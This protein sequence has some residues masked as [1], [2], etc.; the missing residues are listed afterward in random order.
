MLDKAMQTRTR[1]PGLS[2]GMALIVLGGLPTMAIV[3]LVPNLPQLFQQFS[4]VPNHE[5]W[6]PMI[7][8]MPSLCV[9][10]FSPLAG[11]IADFWG[12]RKLLIASLLLFSVVGVLPMLVNN[13]FTI[14]A[15][16]FFV[17]VAE[18]GI[19]TCGNALMGDYFSGAQRHLWLGR[20]ATLGTIL[21]TLFMLSGGAL[22]SQNWHAPFALYAIGLPVALWVLRDMWEPEKRIEAATSN[23]TQHS[24]FP[25]SAAALVSAATI[26]IAIIYFVQ[27]VQ[28]GR[29]FAD[30]GV[31]SPGRISV[32]TAMASIG[33]LL[34]GYFYRKVAAYGVGRVL[35]LAFAAFAIGYVGVSQAPNYW[36]GLP[37]AMISQFGNGLVFPALLNWALGNYDFEHRGRGMGLWGSCFFIGMFVSPPLVTAIGKPIGSFLQTVGVIGMACAVVA[38]IAFWRAQRNH[39]PVVLK[40]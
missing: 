29:I 34:G 12:R 9:A 18:A 10:L 39:F 21:A 16:R 13:L 19:L 8:T 38:I 11:T 25:W 27:A 31:E 24:R 40:E 7:I 14:I 15:T 22:G 37:L 17:G 26:G 4:Q 5:F 30:L 33:V 35:A 28:L 32:F 3:S 6:V 1:V 2:Q 23:T 20:Q 36:V